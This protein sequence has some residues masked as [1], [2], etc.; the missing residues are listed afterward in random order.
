MIRIA[1]LDDYQRVAFDMADWSAVRA[2]AEIVAFDRNL[3]EDEAASVLAP[4]DIVCHL[5]ERM[6]FPRALI[7]ALPNLKLIC[8]TGP[9]HRTLD[10]AAATARGIAVSNT[11]GHGDGAHATPELALGLMLAAAR[12]IALEDRRMR[13]GLWQGTV[14]TVLHGKTLGIVGLGRVGGRVAS[15]ARAFGMKI[16]AWSENLTDERAAACGATRVAKDELFRASDIVS[17]HLVLSER[18]RGIVGA[19]D[20]ALMKRTAYLVNT[21]RGPIVDEAALIDALQRNAIAGAALDVYALEPLPPDHPLRALDNAVL[22]PH[23]GYVSEEGYRV[24]YGETVENIL[25][26]L[27]G[28]PVRILNPEAARR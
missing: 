22:T 9:A 15:L 20:I 19:R 6:P 7:A 3:A 4:F 14:G 21:A 11:T 17:L 27:D 26:F 12:H 10:L 18:T 8:V 5:R 2:R 1:I 25:A 23:L 13:H 24:Y 16:I 28:N